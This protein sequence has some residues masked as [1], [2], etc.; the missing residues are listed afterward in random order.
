[1]PFPAD[2]EALRDG[3]T[4]FLTEAFRATGALDGN[5]VTRITELHEVAGGSTGRKVVLSVEYDATSPGLQSRT[6]RQVLPRL[7]Q[8]DS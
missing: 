5:S 2:T 8:R 7:R 1:M 3:G 4:R 6:V